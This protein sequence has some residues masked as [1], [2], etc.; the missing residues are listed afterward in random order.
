MDFIILFCVTYLILDGLFPAS[1]S[2]KPRRVICREDG[3][4]LM[5]VDDNPGDVVMN[6]Y[7]Q[8]WLIRRNG[9]N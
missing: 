5:F 2:T 4:P 7:L 3:S 6:D 1:T 8:Q 9:A